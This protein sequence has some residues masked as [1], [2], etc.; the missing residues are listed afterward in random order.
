MFLIVYLGISV[1]KEM[2]GKKKENVLIFFISF[3]NSSGVFIHISLEHL[4]KNT[5]KVQEK[6]NSFF[7]S[8]KDVS[9]M[10]CIL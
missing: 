2:G 10:Q 5:K 8:V 1:K 9:V 6:K 4:K 3:K 7:H